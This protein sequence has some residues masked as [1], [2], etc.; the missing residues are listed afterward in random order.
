LAP[1]FKE[2]FGEGPR[3][4]QNV[5]VAHK[6]IRKME[7]DAQRRHYRYVYDSNVPQAPLMAPDTVMKL[8]EK[9]TPE[10]LKLVVHKLLQVSTF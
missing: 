1:A 5:D 10:W 9:P 2:V 4:P 3:L 6:L 8:E 7:V